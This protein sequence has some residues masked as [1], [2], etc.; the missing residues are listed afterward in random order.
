VSET[1]DRHAGTQVGL[2]ARCVHAVRQTSA[3]GSHFW[4]CRAADSDPTLLRYPPLPVRECH[5]FRA[6]SPLRSSA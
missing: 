5:A 3:R 2:C 1:G 6:G 4:R